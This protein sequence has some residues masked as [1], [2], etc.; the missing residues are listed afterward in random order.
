[1]KSRSNEIRRARPL[2]GTLVEIGAVGANAVA[3]IDAAF[4]EIAAVH[5]L[6]SFHEKDSDVSRLNRAAPGEIVCVDPRTYEVLA[7]A[8]LMS[9]LSCGA[10]DVTVG[11]NLV[12]AGFLPQPQGAA[13][14]DQ[15]ASFED[16]LLL[17]ENSV[18]LT[19]RV[20]IDLGG[21]AKGYAVDRAVQVLKQSGLTSGIVNA[22]GDLYAFGEP[23]PIHVRHP[24]NGSLVLPLGAISN[25]AL[26][27]SSGF[28][29]AQS[30][31]DALVEP[32]RG[33]CVKWRQGVTVIAPRCMIADALTK[34]VRL[35]PR[36]APTILSQFDAQALTVDRRGIRCSAQ[37]RSTDKPG[38]SEAF[39]IFNRIETAL[40]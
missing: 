5:Q 37:L 27:S 34:V 11:G 3:G 35:A 22:G 16:L 17:V 25:A 14:F 20:W 28:F 30:F 18:T 24:Q 15:K 38:C 4:R 23:Q 36:R 7:C 19:R 39:E 29:S 12:A 1:M 9:R 10:F 31:Q 21:I 32:K 6:M 40:A 8:Q 33:R 13:A 26:A 2:L